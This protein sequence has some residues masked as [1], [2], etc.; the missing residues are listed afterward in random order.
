MAKKGYTPEQIINKPALLHILAFCC[1][2]ILPG[3]LARAFTHP[4]E[5]T[6]LRSLAPNSESGKEEKDEISNHN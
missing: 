1:L 3:R 4:N 5:R 2:S 6:K